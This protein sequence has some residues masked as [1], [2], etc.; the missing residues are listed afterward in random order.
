MVVE[1]DVAQ[2]CLVAEVEVR[3]VVGR[4]AVALIE[5]AMRVEAGT[6]AHLAGVSKVAIDAKQWTWMGR[7]VL[8][9]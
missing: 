8:A 4:G 2:V 7:H 3:P 5:T 6:V 9:S 1:K